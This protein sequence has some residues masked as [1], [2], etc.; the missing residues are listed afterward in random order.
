M[1]SVN[2]NGDFDVWIWCSSSS[3]RNEYVTFCCSPPDLLDSVTWLTGTQVRILRTEPPPAPA[4]KRAALAVLIDSSTN[5]SAVT[6]LMHTTRLFRRAQP[7]VT[8]KKSPTSR[9]W[10]ADE[11]TASVALVIAVRMIG[12]SYEAAIA[13]VEPLGTG[14]VDLFQR[15]H[16]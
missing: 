13:A 10:P 1:V 6:V 16:D 4:M 7:E 2:D 9:S 5:E 14:R 11:T 3:S 8:S 12:A 15:G